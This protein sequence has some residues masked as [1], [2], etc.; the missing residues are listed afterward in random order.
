VLHQ[1]LRHIVPTKPGSLQGHQLLLQRL[2]KAD[3]PGLLRLMPLVEFFVVGDRQG[4]IG[5]LAAAER[6]Q[7]L[8][9]LKLRLQG[10]PLGCQGLDALA[11]GMMLLRQAGELAFELWVS[12]QLLDQALGRAV[13]DM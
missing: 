10:F 4:F 1:P 7:R 5:V 12:T 9:R 6:S 8:G 11:S 3:L 2:G 13:A